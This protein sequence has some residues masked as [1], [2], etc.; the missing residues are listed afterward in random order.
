MRCRIIQR[1]DGVPNR[2]WVDWLCDPLNFEERNILAR[3]KARQEAAE[4]EDARAAKRQRRAEPAVE[5]MPAEKPAPGQIE[6]LG[7]F[8]AAFKPSD[9]WIVSDGDGRG[10]RIIPNGEQAHE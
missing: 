9:P 7:E 8:L 10:A 6:Q 4:Q 2:D 1:A 3:N 5:L